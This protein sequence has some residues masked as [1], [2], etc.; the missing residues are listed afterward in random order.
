MVKIS[1]E[2]ITRFNSNQTTSQG[3]QRY[4]GS[5]RYFILIL[6]TALFSGLD[7]AKCICDVKLLQFYLIKG[8]K[9]V[10]NLECLLNTSKCYTCIWWQFCFFVG[11]HGTSNRA[12]STWSKILCLI[13]VFYLQTTDLSDTGSNPAYIDIA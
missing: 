7:H 10:E 5:N 8:K 2:I 13:L 12:K 4:T 11:I 3:Y 1:R 9:V 6:Y